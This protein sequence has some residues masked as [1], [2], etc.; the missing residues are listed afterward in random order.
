MASEI[1]KL[2]GYGDVNAHIHPSI[3]EPKD[4]KGVRVDDGT[5]EVW[6]VLW[7]NTQGNLL[8]PE[9]KLFYKGHFV[10]WYFTEVNIREAIHRKGKYFREVGL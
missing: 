4:E 5:S 2:I 1:D 7:F 6:K 9:F 3:E 10:G 8:C